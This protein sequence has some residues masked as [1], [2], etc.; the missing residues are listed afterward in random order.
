MCKVYIGIYVDL[1]FSF[2][3]HLIS[4]L[5]PLVMQNS[6]LKSP[7]GIPRLRDMELLVCVWAFTIDSV[8][9]VCGL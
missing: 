1:P 6:M 9:V 2:S 7:K 3:H 4:N 8:K 5:Q